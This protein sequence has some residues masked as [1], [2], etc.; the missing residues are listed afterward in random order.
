MAISLVM[1]SRRVLTV[2]YC[3]W[4]LCP[5]TVAKI[6]P[7]I[8]WNPDNPWFSHLNNNARKV[9]PFDKLS[10]RCPN[11]MDYPIERDNVYSKDKLYENLFMVDKKGFDS[12]NATLGLKLLS[13][14][15]PDVPSRHVTVVFQPQSANE[16][17]P[18]FEKGEEYYFINTASGLITSLTNLEGGR[19][20]ENQ[21]KMK[22]YVC[23]EGNDP[24]CPHGN[25]VV[26]GGWS[27]WS[28]CTGGGL[29]SRKCNLPYPENGGLPCIGE[30]ER[31][32]TTKAS[33]VL[34]CRGN[35]CSTVTTEGEPEFP[36][37]ESR[38]GDNLTED[39]LLI[40]KGFFAGICLIILVVGLLVG[41][42]VT[43]LLCR[44]QR[45]KPQKANVKMT[46]VP[47]ALS[48]NRPVSSFTNVS[49]GSKNMECA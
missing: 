34:G 2:V 43:M 10:I 16:N 42:G 17:D 47:S 22:I 5:G 37:K 31:A 30:A 7:S 20:K 32:C 25:K 28:E 3:L 35:S 39:D 40:N 19:C 6:L 11:L 49:M 21:M 38:T 8:L 12:C 24:K 13:C 46:R 36:S 4:L 23:K 26:H 33:Q 27:D 44:M 9:L 29:Q 18:K 15:N 41:G 1:R 45:R 14:D 48:T